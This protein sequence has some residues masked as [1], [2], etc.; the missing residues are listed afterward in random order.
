M[1]PGDTAKID[2]E[3]TRNG[4]CRIFVWAEPLAGY[5][6]VHVREHRTAR[7]WADEMEHLLTKCYPDK[8]KLIL[9]MDNLN[10]HGIAS[11]YKRIPAATARA[12]ANPLQR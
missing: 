5:R 7:D 1:R 6:Y 10:V 2:S 4:S 3:Y 8:D 11:P 9:V 12:Y